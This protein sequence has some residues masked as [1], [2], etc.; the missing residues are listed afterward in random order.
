M[1]TMQANELPSL[2][3]EVKK[4][5][6]DGVYSLLRSFNRESTY[7]LVTDRQAKGYVIDLEGNVIDV[8]PLGQPQETLS[9]EPVT[10]SIDDLTCLHINIH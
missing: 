10:F 3:M 1:I 9:G 8:L 5:V 4:L 7:L 2:S 6:V